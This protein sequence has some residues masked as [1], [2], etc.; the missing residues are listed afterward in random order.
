MK[1]IGHII[2]MRSQTLVNQREITKINDLLKSWD[3]TAARPQLGESP[4]AQCP[5]FYGSY[6]SLQYVNRMKHLV[7]QM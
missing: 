5:S 2:V 4:G 7:K 1:Q 6:G 3:P